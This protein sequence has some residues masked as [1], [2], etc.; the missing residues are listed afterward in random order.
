MFN[1]LEF[2]VSFD[3]RRHVRADF[4]NRYA[5]NFWETSPSLKEPSFSERAAS[6]SFPTLIFAPKRFAI[7]LITDEMSA[8][9][10]PRC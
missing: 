7:F 10:R 5:R 9:S 8:N 3:L 2:H 6:G 4:N 1:Y